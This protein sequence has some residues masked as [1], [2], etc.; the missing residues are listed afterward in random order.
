MRA[1]WLS[2]FAASLCLLVSSPARA[3][4]LTNGD[5]ETSPVPVGS[6]TNFNSGST[7]IP[8]WTV[9][10]PQ[11]SI[12]SG[13]FTQNGFSFP[14]ESGVQWVDMTGDG[15]NASEGVEQTVPTTPSDA[16]SLS[17]WVGNIVDPDGIFGTTST[18]DVLV[19]GTQISSAENSA[20]A[21]TSVQNWEQ[22]TVPFTA[23]GSSTTIELLNADPSN[24]NSNGL[25]NVTLIQTGGGAPVVPLPSTAWATLVML[26]GLLSAKLVI[27]RRAHRI[28]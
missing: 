9:V 12:I 27:G 1:F 24:D 8:G 25:D 17:F 23:T 19:N 26:I 3:T 18:V 22:F 13:T 2:A 15:S 16:Y 4:L 5:F 10:G 7:L 11:V 6:F 20:G 14:A 21:G 28:A